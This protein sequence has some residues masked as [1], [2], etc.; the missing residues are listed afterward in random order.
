[1]I[2]LILTSAGWQRECEKNQNLMNSESAK[3]LECLEKKQQAALAAENIAF[4]IEQCNDGLLLLDNAVEKA[5]NITE[6][7]VKKYITKMSNSHT[8]INGYLSQLS[9]LQSRLLNIESMY[10]KMVQN[11]QDNYDEYFNRKANAGSYA[12]TAQYNNR[13]DSVTG[14]FIPGVYTGVYYGTIKDEMEGVTWVE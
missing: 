4:F 13:T 3:K 5:E 9:G 11:H 2:T 10:Q 1:M 12:T 14:E 7:T 8:N 6:N